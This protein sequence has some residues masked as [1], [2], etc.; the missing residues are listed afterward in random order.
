LEHTLAE[1]RR[2][3]HRPAALAT[4]S[5]LFSLLLYFSL[6]DDPAVAPPVPLH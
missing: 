3:V 1:E 6:L 2:Q 4:V 5:L